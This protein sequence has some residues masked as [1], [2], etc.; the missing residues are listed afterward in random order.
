MQ[1]F[2]KT[3]LGMT[4]PVHSFPLKIYETKNKKYQLFPPVTRILDPPPP[5]PPNTPPHTHIHPPHHPPPHTLL[6][7]S[8]A[9]CTIAHNI[10]E[11]TKLILSKTIGWS[12]L[13][14]F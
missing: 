5:P 8:H 12:D 3:F 2:R 11:S 9:H 1:S 6:P 4:L 13:V 14:F 10:T 7:W